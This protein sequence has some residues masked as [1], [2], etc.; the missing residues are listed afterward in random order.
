MTETTPLCLPDVFHPY[1]VGAINSTAPKTANRAR[2]ASLPYLDVFD[3]LKHPEQ[4][5]PYEPV[6]VPERPTHTWNLYSAIVVSTLSY[7]TEA[8]KRLHSRPGQRVQYR[9]VASLDCEHS[10]NASCSTD[11]WPAACLR[12]FL[13]PGNM[14]LWTERNWGL[15]MPSAPP[16]FTRGGRCGIPA[17]PLSG[18]VPNATYN[19]AYLHKTVQYGD[20]VDIIFNNLSPFFHPMHMHGYDFVVLGSRYY[21]DAGYTNVSGVPQN[22]AGTR[23]RAPE[24]VC[25][26]GE[27]SKRQLHAADDMPL[28]SK[29]R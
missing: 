26:N 15:R 3:S 11:V 1:R 29:G 28:M 17:E 27:R 7:T 19:K 23:I 24:D 12:R 9:A 22:S 16:L 6:V 25:P 21:M 20:V 5:I 2:L 18:Q 14:Y 10:A 8:M 13:Q 4:V